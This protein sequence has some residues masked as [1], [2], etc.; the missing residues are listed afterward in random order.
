MDNRAKKGTLAWVTL[1]LAAA[2]W[3]VS[4]EA[5][6]TQS[7]DTADGV[8]ADL[9]SVNVQNSIVT[10]RF[11]FRNTGTSQASIKIHYKDC[12]I[13]DETNQKKYYALKDADGL[14]I[15]GPMYDQN[16]GG[17]FWYDIPAGK[18]KGLWIKFPE[19]VDKPSL[20]TVAIPEVPPFENVKLGR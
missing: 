17:R 2:G 6:Q 13:M 3:L 8:E 5:L 19:P 7:H 9:L 20:I 11:K 18:S 15:A 12:Y 14:Y 1:F 16:N 4:Q 10:L